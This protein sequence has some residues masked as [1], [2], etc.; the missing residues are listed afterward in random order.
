MKQQQQGMRCWEGAAGLVQVPGMG[1]KGGHLT[2]TSR[3]L[4]LPGR[5]NACAWDCRKLKLAY[6]LFSVHAGTL[7]F[8]IPAGHI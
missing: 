1:K 7:A 4:C 6:S 2:V 8:I 3:S 5:S